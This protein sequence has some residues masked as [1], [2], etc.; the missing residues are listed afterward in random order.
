VKLKPDLICLGGAIY[1]G[2]LLH[3]HGTYL[4]YPAKLPEPGC[5]RNFEIPKHTKSPASYTRA[6]TTGDA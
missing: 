2:T 5:G 1:V 3:M 4:L 6:S